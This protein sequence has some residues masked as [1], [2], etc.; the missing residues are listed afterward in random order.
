MI[1]VLIGFLLMIIGAASLTAL[2]DKISCNND[3][4]TFERCNM[5]KTLVVVS[6]IDTVSMVLEVAVESGSE[7]GQVVR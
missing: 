6:W 7:R 2:T 4:Q 1:P 3:S 5:M